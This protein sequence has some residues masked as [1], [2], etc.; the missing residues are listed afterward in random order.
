MNTVFELLSVAAHTRRKLTWGG[1]KLIQ[2]LFSFSCISVWISAD[3]HSPD[4]SLQS[5]LFPDTGAAG[6]Y[7]QAY[8]AGKGG[9]SNVFG[10]T[11]KVG[12][13]RN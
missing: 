3:S 6:Q 10:N 7:H 13:H 2:L 1:R 8:V 11:K 12:I 5:L 9:Q 4:K